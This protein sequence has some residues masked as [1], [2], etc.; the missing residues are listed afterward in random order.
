MVPDAN[1]TGLPINRKTFRL[2]GVDKREQAVKK[3]QGE[4]GRV[5]SFH[6]L[7]ATQSGGGAGVNKFSQSRAAIYWQQEVIDS[8]TSQITDA[9]GAPITWNADATG[10]G[11]LVQDGNSI[12]DYVGL[13][14]HLRG[15]TSTIAADGASTTYPEEVKAELENARSYAGWRYPD[16]DA[17]KNLIFTGDGAVVNITQALDLGAGSITFNSDYTLAGARLN[18]AGFIVNEGAQVTTELTSHY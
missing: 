14:N 3:A 8:Y 17:T 10:S 1:L 15:A 4:N 18:S 12:G 13:P 16:L 9:G 2:N 7:A 6:S 11:N 5:I